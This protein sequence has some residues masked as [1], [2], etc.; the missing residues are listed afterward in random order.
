MTIISLLFQNYGNPSHDAESSKAL[1]SYDAATQFLMPF[2]GNLLWSKCWTTI[3]ANVYIGT[4][5]IT[6]A[7][8]EAVIAALCTMVIV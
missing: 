3:S 2:Q 7:D 8:I 6:H 4:S 5:E 1:A